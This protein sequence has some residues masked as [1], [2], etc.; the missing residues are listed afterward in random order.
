MRN[1]FA[2]LLAA[3][4]ALTV[5]TQA[6]ATPANHARRDYHV[7]ILAL[8]GADAA[9]VA[10][11]AERGKPFEAVVED[12][13]K[14]QPKAVTQS[15]TLR[16]DPGKPMRFSSSEEI[17]YENG[18]RIGPKGRVPLPKGKVLIG[19]RIYMV[20]AKSGDLLTVS[21]DNVRLVEFMTL[22]AG[23]A[24]GSLTQPHT[25]QE[26]MRTTVDAKVGKV[27]ALPIGH[28]KDGRTLVL[29]LGRSA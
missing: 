8:P 15:V 29:V 22:D 3:T 7:A 21:S 4:A 28:D 10:S 27:H 24:L 5:A 14:G 6:L 20:P 11:A 26:T 25:E 2:A 9:S 23:T 19:T 13:G 18:F 1:S 17:P 12:L 16:T